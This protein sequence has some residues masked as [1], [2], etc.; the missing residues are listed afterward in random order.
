MSS[1]ETLL[2]NACPELE[3]IPFSFADILTVKQIKLIRC[4]NKTLE[5][6]A[7]KI[8][9]DIEENE[10]CDRVDLITI[11]I[12]VSC[13]ILIRVLRGRNKDTAGSIIC[14]DLNANR[15]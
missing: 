6:S 10:G 13:S 8:K 15:F 3:E 2:I 9:N 1:T 5:A 7:L 12:S 14:V 4:D 11:E